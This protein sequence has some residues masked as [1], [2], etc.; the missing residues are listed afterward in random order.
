[1]VDNQILA[2]QSQYLNVTILMHLEINQEGRSSI[3]VVHRQI[4][5]VHTPSYC[6]LQTK[7]RNDA[8]KL[9]GYYWTGQMSLARNLDIMDAI[10]WIL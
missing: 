7:L 3:V 9:Y 4:V 8:Q 5:D 10:L 1:M 2:D 6:L